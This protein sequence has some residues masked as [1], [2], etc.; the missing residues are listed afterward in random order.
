MRSFFIPEP[1]L[2]CGSVLVLPVE[3]RK[4]IR[5]VLRLSPGDEVELFNGTGQVARGVLDAL[6]Q[7]QVLQVE[8]QP[9]AACRLTLLQGLPKGEKLELILQK[10]TEI[11]VG[12]FQVVAM[13]RSVGRLK[14][15]KKEQKLGRWWKIIQEAA[16][17]SRQYHLPELQADLSLP[18]ALAQ[19]QA[20]LKLVLWE[21]EAGSLAAALPRRMPQSIAVIVGPEGGISSNEIELIKQAGFIPV[22]L[23]PRILR[24]E[25]AG[26][27]IMSILQYLYGDF[28]TGRHG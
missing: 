11:G 22:G 23:G 4:H 17:Q 26:L 14:T 3:Q 2:S 5:T 27:A 25:T 20:D 21:E 16:R 18:Q 9:A 15:E 24:T 19:V 8:T 6:D 12:C 28:A 13:E 10:G 1:E 7:V